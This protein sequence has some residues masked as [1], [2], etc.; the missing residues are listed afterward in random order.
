MTPKEIKDF[1]KSHERD[2][3]DDAH[4][5]I[6]EAMKPGEEFCDTCFIFSGHDFLKN[7]EPLLH[8]KWSAFGNRK[9]LVAHM[10][11]SLFGDRDALE[12]IQEAFIEYYSMLIAKGNKD[13]LLLNLRPLLLYAFGSKKQREIAFKPD[14]LE[15][16]IANIKA[17]NPSLEQQVN[18]MEQ[19]MKH[20]RSI[21]R[22][23]FATLLHREITKVKEQMALDEQKAT[24]ERSNANQRIQI[25]K[26]A[27]RVRQLRKQEAL[28]Q[29]RLEHDY[30]SMGRRIKNYRTMIERLQ[31]EMDALVEQQRELQQQH[32]QFDA[33]SAAKRK[34]QQ[35]A[36]RKRERAAH[37]KKGKESLQDNTRSCSPMLN[38]RGA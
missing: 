32:P 31:A 15:P 21:G 4:D 35:L 6:L 34:R 18:A 23:D 11:T 27:S 33:N 28:E 14:D 7:G 17:A 25:A 12:V 30:D 2:I 3:V 20:F 36:E 19:Q 22:R 24:A 5:A 10:A 29:Q 8:H 37:K 1:N 26:E 9:L 13:P 38:K 16:Q